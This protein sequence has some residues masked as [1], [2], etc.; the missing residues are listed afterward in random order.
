MVTLLTGCAGFIGN[1]TTLALLQKGDAVVGIDNLNDYYSVKLKN[2]RLM[3]ITQR[4]DSPGFKANGID[5]KFH[6]IKADICDKPKLAEIFKDNKIDAVIHLAA[7][8]GV[9]YSLENP[10]AY[11]DSNLTGTLNIFE[12][13][14]N[15]KVNNIV[16][17]SSSSVYGDNAK[18]PFSVK[19]RTDSPV[20][21]YAATKKSCE[22]MAYTYNHLFGLNITGLRFF[23]VYGPWGR[24]DM[25]LLLFAKSILE[26]KPIKIFGNG[27]MKRDFTYIDD[28]VN[29]IIAVLDWNINLG[30]AAL[31]TPPAKVFNIGRGEPVGLMRFIEILEN[32][33]EKS[34]IKEFLPMQPGDVPATWADT[35]ELERLV[36]Y[37][38]KISLEYGVKEFVKWYKSEGFSLF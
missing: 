21:L 23:T 20:S 15:F 13:C 37:K 27:N 3:R 7:Q 1:A 2:A 36:G 25:A 10:Q 6:F 34:A 30:T 31:T 24:P 18:I 28:I 4:C 29:G 32:E 9:R 14:R 26:N 12:C 38:P 22:L 33:L 8:A 5:S 19:D 35:A 16:F 11:I 17:A